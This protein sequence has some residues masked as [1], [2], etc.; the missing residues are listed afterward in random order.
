[1]KN[2]P[3][4]PANPKPAAFSGERGLV[5]GERVL[6]N[7]K[8]ESGLFVLTDMR[9]LFLGEGT[10]GNIFSASRLE[11]VV[12]VRV[13]QVT[14]LWRNLVWVLVG[15]AALAGLV[16]IS[17][18]IPLLLIAGGI[19]LLGIL[20]IGLD[21]A[22]HPSKRVLVFGSSGGAVKGAVKSVNALDLR[23][24]VAAVENARITQPDLGKVDSG[25]LKVYEQTPPNQI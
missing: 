2:N 6:R 3:Y 11:H 19:L 14:R 13:E 21:Y 17:D 5:K 1:M 25:R 20:A 22:L 7:M 8:A 4:D 15:L 24:F 10:E 9:V 18:N 23:E 16:Q 12:S